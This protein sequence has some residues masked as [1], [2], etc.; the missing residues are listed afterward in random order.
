MDTIINSTVGWIPTYVIDPIRVRFQVLRN[1]GENIEELR[2]RTI[3]LAGRRDSERGKVE[4]EKKQQGVEAS[5]EADS[6]FGEVNNALSNAETL[7]TEYDERRSSGACQ[8]YCFCWSGYQLSKKALKLKEVVEGLYEAEPKSGWT[9][10]ASTSH[11][12]KKL[13]TVSIEGQTRTEKLKQEMIDAVVDDRHVVVGLYGM[14]GIGKTTLLRHVYEHFRQTEHFDSVIFTTVSS[15][16]KFSE[17]REEIAKGLGLNLKDCQ[18]ENDLREKLCRLSETMKYML[19]LDDMWEP[20]DLTEICILAPKKENGCKLL[21]SSRSKDVVTRFVIPFAAKKSLRSIQVNKLGEDEA[22]ELFVQKVGEDI[23][24]EPTIEPIA[25]E[26]LK[27]C[28]GLPLA[29]IVIGGTMS[30]RET[31]GQWK[32]AIRELEQQSN[33]SLE[34]IEKEVF[35]KLMFSF[36]K[37]EPIQQSLFLYC[38]LFPKDWNQGGGS[39]GKYFLYNFAIGEETLCDEMHRL[40][41]MRNKVDVLVGKLQSS[42]IFEHAN[43]GHGRM[44]DVMYELGMWIT[45]PT[46]LN[47]YQYSKFI[48][49]ARS[50]ITK[51]PDA[52]EWGKATKISLMWNQI[53]SLPQLPDKCPQLQTL[54]LGG[55][56][57]KEIP[58][59]H[60]LE[61]MPALRILDL[62]RC[63]DLKFLPPSICHLV[64][65]RSLCLECCVNLKELPREIG[66]LAQLIFLDLSCC[67]GLTKLPKEMKKL[68][69]LRHLNISYTTQL[70]RIPRGVLSGLH[71]LEELYTDGSS[72]KWSTNGIMELG[73][74]LAL[75]LT[76]IIRIPEAKI[77]GVKVSHWLKPLAKSIVCLHLQNCDIDPST[78]P[79]LLLLEGSRHLNRTVKFISCNGLT[80]VPAC[81]YSN[82]TI[83]N[84]PD[85][86]QLCSRISQ[87]AESSFTNLGRITIQECPNLEV[88][89]TSGVTCQLKKLKSLHVY[90]CPQLVN[91]IVSD[92]DDEDMEILSN[93][94]PSL[95]EMR[96]C[97]LPEL[98]AICNNH[99]HLDLMKWPSLSAA[100]GAHVYLCPKLRRPPF[101]AHRA[102]ISLNDETDSQMTEKYRKE[103]RDQEEKER[104]KDDDDDDDDDE[105]E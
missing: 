71:K 58:Q 31:E 66:M 6:W 12:G 34:G 7:R 37:L 21:I 32:D 77:K 72:L 81:G 53:E 56:I 50:G 75:R 82:L 49:K 57:I 86:K 30:T 45:S 68:K 24:S 104:E 19:I 76:S 90:Q 39:I 78:L 70:K 85:L 55:C 20:F 47:K 35:S 96:L 15:T 10:T 28:G 60:F 102:D 79:D 27:K 1:L 93:A 22:W 88:L 94:F 41:D 67:T 2:Q 48:A 44:H 5:A 8:R 95:K 74:L 18:D 99:Q 40:E 42:S 92:D 83:R 103:K 46:T 54:L 100:E 69:N 97:E 29:I 38:C 17:I 61:Q 59:V 14:G 26:V 91:L 65:L 11:K 89:F 73:S 36:E 13:D 3:F 101:G 84:C 63:S 87:S 9:A 16:P 52:S 62:N 105:E 98:T 4:E 23:T 43:N 51:A 80:W 64:N 25:K 33:S